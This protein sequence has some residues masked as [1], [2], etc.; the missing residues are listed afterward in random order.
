MTRKRKED[1]YQGDVK[2]ISNPLGYEEM[3]ARIS[4]LLAHDDDS[5]S[6]C[7]KDLGRI[8][9]LVVNEQAPAELIAHCKDKLVA[10]EHLK[11]TLARLNTIY[12][13][14]ESIGKR[15]KAVRDQVDFLKRALAT[16]LYR[17][18]LDPQTSLDLGEDE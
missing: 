3:L 6:Q 12:G 18:L 14:A 15:A 10:M 4:D 7:Q 2:D 8:T 17:D 13:A 11:A 1:A 5:L 16:P 9:D